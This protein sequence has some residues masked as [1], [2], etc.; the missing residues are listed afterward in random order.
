MKDVN[1]LRTDDIRIKENQPTLD[2]FRSD[3]SWGNLI[4]TYFI[5]LKYYLRKSRREIVG[6]NT[7]AEE[8]FHKNLLLLAPTGYGKSTTLLYLYI[9]GNRKAERHFYYLTASV[10]TK[11]RNK[12]NDYDK[13]LRSKIENRKHIDGLI[14]LDG[15]EE[16]YNKNYSGATELLSK[17]ELS[18]NNVWVACR[19]DYYEHISREIVKYYD[20][21]AEIEQWKE[22]E[23]YDFIMHDLNIDESDYIKSIIS[24]LKENTINSSTSIYCPFYAT[25]LMFIASNSPHTKRIFNEYDLI[26]YFLEIWLSREIENKGYAIGVDQC[27]HRLKEIAIDVYKNK[28]PT[29]K[30]DVISDAI[31]GLL[32]IP[33]YRSFV[34]DSFYHREFLVYLIVSGMIEAA[35]NNINE[36]VYWYS[37]T[38]YDDV[39]NLYKRALESLDREKHLLIYHNLYNVYKRSYEDIHSIKQELGSYSYKIDKWAILRL[40]DEILYFIFRLYKTNRE[41]LDAFFDYAKKHC[42]YT[43]LSL[44]LAYG[45]AGIG[46]H[47]YTLEFAKKL[48]NNSD[49]EIVNRSWAVCFFGDVSGDGF[50]YKDTEKCSWN[51]VKRAKLKRLEKHEEKA[52]RYR[53][54]DLPLLKCFYKSREYEGCTSY[55]EYMKIYNIDIS[56]SGYSDDEKSF[57]EEQKATLVM[58]YRKHLMD[59]W[60]TNNPLA[61]KQANLEDEEVIMEMIETTEMVDNNL[62]TFWENRGPEIINK[63]QQRLSVPAGRMINSDR[64]GEELRKCKVLIITANYVEGTT[65]TRLLM[66]HNNSSRLERI[67]MDNHIYQFSEINGTKIVHI[68]PQGTS[69]FTV[70]GSFNALVAALKRFTPEFVFAIGVAF[71]GN[72][73][74]QELGDVLVSDHL[75]FYDSFN[76]LTDGKLKL[77]VDEVQRVGDRILAACQFLKRKESPSEF[78]IGNY[79]WH[80]GTL[81]SGGTVLSDAY[82]KKRLINA[83]NNMGYEII[84]GEMEG[85]GIYFA[86]NGVGGEIPFVIIKGI[87]D[88]GINKNGWSFVSEKKDEQDEIKDCVQAF[89]CENAFMTL[90]YML[91]QLLPQD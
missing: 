55:K 75:V 79:K 39:T 12:L 63:Y 33:H 69:S 77:S 15:L 73:G 19:P 91:S 59:A 66:D 87:C 48:C 62:K 10:F 2:A 54:L 17:I 81:L 42:D 34:V 4:E 31:R 35:T 26:A 6:V 40:R 49:E 57:L 64:L 11:K 67:Q 32:R 38:F 29:L 7:L 65:V 44:G 30:D 83:A 68:W 20:D 9:K 72:A 86:C 3:L 80:L 88:W 60:K 8:C 21:I 90:V 28:Y 18:K 27:L 74:E 36:I 41:D 85:S 52:Y 89:S 1:I 43:M 14:L 23:F 25:I 53:L 70:H 24:S 71:G 37:Q 5:D 84:G 61:D 58:E 13:V 78:R 82:E 56:Y 47:P 45:M 22:T 50:S 46:Q 51:N 16:A 76:K